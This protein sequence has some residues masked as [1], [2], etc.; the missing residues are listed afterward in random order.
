MKKKNSF[1]MKNEKKISEQKKIFDGLLP[2]CGL[3]RRWRARSALGARGARRWACV[4]AR[5]RAQVSAGAR[6]RWGARGALGRRVAGARAW[7]AG[8]AGGM[9]AGAL[10]STG[11]GA[12]GAGA[13]GRADG[14]A[15]GAC[16][17]GPAGRQARGLG[18]GRA[19][20][21]PGLALGSA[22]G[23]LDPL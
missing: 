17:A 15:R 18:A 9:G 20:W 23:A 4:G 14:G 1:M 8:R 16:G 12:R 3:G 11:A 5:E 19:A 7:R 2:I 10:G 13:R 22:L 21:A 6:R